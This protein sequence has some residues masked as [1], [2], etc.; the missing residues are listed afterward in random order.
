[1]GIAVGEVAELA[2]V[3]RYAKVTMNLRD[4]VVLWENAILFKKSASL[5]GSYY[6]EIDP[7]TAEVQTASGQIIETERIP[8]GGEIKRV[9]EATSIDALVRRIDQTMPK[10]DAV[11]VSTRQLSEDVRRIVNGPLEEMLVRI[12]RLVQ[13]EADTVS[14]ILDR[15]DRTLARI[16]AI[17]R[18]IR[19]VTRDADDKVDSILANLDEASAEAREL[20]AT[21]K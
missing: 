7:G 8:P 16:E 13:D 17:T 5:L 21:A 2:I 14:Q 20:V 6:L 18:D 1:A 12:N 9:V 4:D 3:G 11:L 19:S 10:V 15:T